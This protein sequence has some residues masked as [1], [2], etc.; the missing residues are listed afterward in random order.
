MS[1]SEVIAASEK[2]VT[3]QSLAA[4]LRRL[5]LR[6]GMTVLVHS[7]LSS[8]GWVCGGSTA[9]IRALLAVVG[10]DGTLV[11][12][13]HSAGSDPAGWENPPVPRAW[14]DTIRATTPPFDPA[15][16]PTRAIGVIP[17]Q[18]RT[19]PGVVRSYHPTGS[20]AARG[21]LQAHHR[22]TAAGRPV[23]RAIAA[24]RDRRIGRLDPAARGRSPPL[25]HA[26]PGGAAGARRGPGAGA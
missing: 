22:R 9:V 4:D 2:P 23:R 6:A 8:L 20:F 3:E 17:E 24:R 1:E 26:A 11:M 7:S 21:P 18:F 14:W 5:G 15:I 16:T 10:T 19:W 12:P 25:Y 13:A